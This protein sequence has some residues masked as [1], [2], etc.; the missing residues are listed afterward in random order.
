MITQ[1][2]WMNLRALKPL[3]DAGYSYAAIAA[4]A[5]CD[6]RTAKKYLKGDP[7]TP[8]YGP[9]PPRAKLIDPFTGVID[10]WLRA[11][12]KIK[13]KTI[14]E[15]LVADP[16]DFPG[17]YQRVKQYVR[18]RRPQIA[19]E[20][21]LAETA[22]MHRRFETIAGAQAQVDWGDEGTIW[23]PAGELSAYSFHMVLG[24]SRDP[25]CCYV[26]S[27]DLA[28]FWDCHRRAF[29]HFGGVPATILYDRTKTV[30]K[31]HVGKGPDGSVELHPE[32]VAFAAHYDFAI[33]LCWPY[34]PETKGKVERVVGL[35]REKVLAG[36]TFTSTTDM[37]G[38][39]KTW[40]P[41][42]RAQVHRTHGDVIAARA[43]RDRA[44]LRS[45]PARPYIVSDRHLRVVGKDA[46]VSFEASLYSVPWTLVRPRQR[47]ELRITKDEVAIF[48]LGSE[49]QHLATHARAPRRGSWVVDEEHWDGLPHGTR[50]HEGPSA[51]AG[52]KRSRNDQP[53]L[54][55]SGTIVARRALSAYDALF[56]GRD[57][58]S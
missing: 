53:P 32:A 52:A 58:A 17:S 5:G 47:V 1:E 49:P 35:T 3:K 16:Y 6:W 45:L 27:Q 8:T 39:W 9:R 24:Y 19:A 11:E 13:A 50:A 15:R 33:V 54:P 12:I 2:D 14:H 51:S 46:L 55:G 41:I 31:N 37:N 56:Q 34:R 21:G 26:T 29:D 42:R 43:E 18:I 30:V 25:F 22:P 7:A 28:T 57:Q 4:E 40:L 38:A 10:E 23:T 44:A 20:L 48:T 36:R